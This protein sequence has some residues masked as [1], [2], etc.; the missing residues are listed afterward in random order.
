VK[1]RLRVLRGPYAG[2]RIDPADPRGRGI[3][4]TVTRLPI[5]LIGRARA[6][7]FQTPNRV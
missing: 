1:G 7:I 6:I 4:P 5:K 3:I 2:D